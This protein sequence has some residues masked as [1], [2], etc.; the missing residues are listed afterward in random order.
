MLQGDVRVCVAETEMQLII[1]PA[2]LNPSV[3]AS[4]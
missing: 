1:Q 4:A 2:I 3:A